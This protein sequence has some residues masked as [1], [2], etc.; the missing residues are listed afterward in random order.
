MGEDQE[1]EKI[2]RKFIHD[3]RTPI[4][5]LSMLTNLF[6]SGQISADDL[7]I[8]KEELGKMEKL[9]EEHSSNMQ[10]FYK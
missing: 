9:V 4:S 6:E 2:S 5:V 3:I 10:G 8:M 1:L 7:K